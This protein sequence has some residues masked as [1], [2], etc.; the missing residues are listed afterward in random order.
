MKMINVVEWLRGTRDLADVAIRIMGEP[1]WS[2][3]TENIQYI[4][5]DFL[6]KEEPPIFSASS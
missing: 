1:V 5:V 4:Y 2:A 3:A 6:Q